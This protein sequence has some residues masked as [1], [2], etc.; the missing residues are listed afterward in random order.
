MQERRTL[1]PLRNNLDRLLETF[2]LVEGLPS[3]RAD[4]PEL[5]EAVREARVAVA[6]VLVVLNRMEGAR[7]GEHEPHP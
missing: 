3:R 5:R 2:A 1:A 4:D 7:P 6:R